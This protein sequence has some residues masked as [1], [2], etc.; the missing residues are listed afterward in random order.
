[1]LLH[2]F[3]GCLDRTVIPTLRNK[4]GKEGNDGKR[5]RL[6]QP[7]A[8]EGHAARLVSSNAAHLFQTKHQDR[9]TLIAAHTGCAW[10]IWDKN[11]KRDVFG[12][13]NL[14]TPEV[15][16]EAAKEAKTGQSVS[17]NWPIGA[18]QTPFSGRK[19][20]VHKVLSFLD[21]PTHQLHGYDDEVEFN[22]QCSSQWDSLVHFHHQETQTAYNGVYV[23]RGTGNEGLF[24][25]DWCTER[26]VLRRLRRALEKTIM[27]KISRR[28]TTGISVEV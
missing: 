18:I 7:A 6:R 28:L 10:G 12:T 9:K 4:T 17:L 11:G 20:L 8:S 1:M 22:T 15:L 13:L 16:A 5:P 21:K 26:R 24:V 23:S 27:I 25:A 14:L 2:C 19:A 3:T